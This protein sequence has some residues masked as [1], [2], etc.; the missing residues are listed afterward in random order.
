MPAGMNILDRYVYGLFFRY[1]FG[2][3]AVLSTL[4]GMIIFFEVVGDFVQAGSTIGLMAAY[5]FYRLPEAVY[6]M[7]PMAVLTAS[8]ITLSIMTRQKETMVLMSCGVSASRIT[9]PIVVA[10]LLIAAGS[11]IIGEYVLPSS[12]ANAADIWNHKVKGYRNISSVK[13]NSVWIKSGSGEIWNIGFF[14]LAAGKLYDVTVIETTLGNDGFATIIRA[15]AGHLETGGGWTLTEVRERRFNPAG[16]AVDLTFSQKTYP[17]LLGAGELER[18]EK[19]P[20]EMNL[21]EIAAYVAHIEKAGYKDARYTVD[22]YAKITFPLIS[23][24]MA[25]L[26]IPF[27]LK[28]R[29]GGGGALTAITLA[30]TLGFMFWFFYSMGISLGHSGKLPPP[31]AAGGAHLLFLLGAAYIF[32]SG[33]HHREGLFR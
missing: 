6:Y 14:N 28:S 5:F 7:I 9:R 11:F 26:A 32:L 2:G 12:W 23:V 27:G 22:M 16:E 31:L 24:V 1:F 19:R 4:F 20:E 30:A 29:R 13:Q 15:G 3:M 18:A 17:F 33:Y 25:A 8:I 10:A 21:R